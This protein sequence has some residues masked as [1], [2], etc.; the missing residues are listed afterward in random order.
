M[1]NI[2]LTERLRGLNPSLPS[3]RWRC[4]LTSGGEAQVSAIYAPQVTG[5]WYTITHLFSSCPFKNILV[6]Y[7]VCISIPSISSK[8]KKCCVSFSLSV[9][10]MIVRIIS[11]ISLFVTVVIFTVIHNKRS[12]T[13]NTTDT[14][15][16]AYCTIM[17][18]TLSLT[19]GDPKAET[20]SP[21]SKVHAHFIMSIISVMAHSLIVFPLSSFFFLKAPGVHSVTASQSL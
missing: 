3:R 4:Q 7:S 18:D 13:W 6:K 20:D 10:H 21:V 12:G 11:T 9:V 19:S 5:Q 15:W 1:C 17:A 14:N 16:H 8:Y 2:I